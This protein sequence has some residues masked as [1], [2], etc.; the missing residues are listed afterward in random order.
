MVSLFSYQCYRSH[1][2]YGKARHERARTS[3]FTAKQ[4]IVPFIYGLFQ[5]FRKTL[6]I[7]PIESEK[8][9]RRKINLI[10]Q[11]V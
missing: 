1:H 6:L 5:G 9:G 7:P 10:S 8:M 2:R 4:R 11:S 3:F